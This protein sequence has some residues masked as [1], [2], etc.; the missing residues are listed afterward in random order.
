MVI[1]RKNKKSAH[2]FTLRERR[3]TPYPSLSGDCGIMWYVESLEN[4][5]NAVDGEPLRRHQF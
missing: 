4:L 5:Y 3:M 2:F 1:S